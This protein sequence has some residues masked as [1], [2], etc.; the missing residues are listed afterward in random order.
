MIAHP[1]LLVGPCN[2]AG[3][4]VPE[5]PADLDGYDPDEYPHWD[6][7]LGV[8]LGRPMPEPT[9]HWKNAKLIAELNDDEIRT[10]TVNDLLKR[11]LSA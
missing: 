11:G 3:I 9:S 1:T 5:N 7:F 10:I 4:K 2:E 8:Q 6:V